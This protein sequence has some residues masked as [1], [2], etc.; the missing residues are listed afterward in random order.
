MSKE[1][2][3]KICMYR[4]RELIQNGR[5][6]F[7]SRQKN[8]QTLFD[9]GLRKEDVFQKLLELQ[10]ADYISGPETDKNKSDGQI[11]KFCHPVSGIIIYIKLKFYQDN[12]TDSLKILS[13]H[14][15]EY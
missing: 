7:V 6:V 10:V 3:I 12:G 13:F 4:I 14:P 9:F 2:A 11:W 1:L 8:R 5:V 15:E